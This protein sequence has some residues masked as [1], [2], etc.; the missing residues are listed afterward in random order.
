MIIEKEI[1]HSVL[2]SVRASVENSVIDSVYGTVCNAVHVQTLNNVRNSVRA[3]AHILVA[4]QIGEQSPFQNR[5]PPTTHN[6]AITT[7][8][9]I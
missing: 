1:N 2:N 4:Q 5:Q 3:S 7:N 6:T 9:S 8:P